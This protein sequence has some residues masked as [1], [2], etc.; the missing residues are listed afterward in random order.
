MNTLFPESE[1]EMANNFFFCLFCSTLVVKEMLIKTTTIIF[2]SIH[3]QKNLPIS[4]FSFQILSNGKKG[5]YLICSLF[6]PSM[7]N[8]T[9]ALHISFLKLFILYWSIVD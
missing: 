5:P 9:V 6:K 1:S 7:Q 3:L 2:H 8:Y 4:Y